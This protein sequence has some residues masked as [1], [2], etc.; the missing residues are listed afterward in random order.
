MS[1]LSQYSTEKKSK[2]LKRCDVKILNHAPTSKRAQ[3]SF[4]LIYLNIDL[5]D[6]VAVLIRL[7]MQVRD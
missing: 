4:P 5:L 6:V 1:E 3:R 2:N 7:E